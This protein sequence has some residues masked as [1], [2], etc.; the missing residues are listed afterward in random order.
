MKSR[1]QGY[2]TAAHKPILSI[3]LGAI[4]VA[5][6]GVAIAQKRG[7]LEHAVDS[8]RRMAIGDVL[9]LYSGLANRTVLHP[10]L[11]GQISIPSN[12]HATNQ[13]ETAHLL[14]QALEKRALTVIRAGE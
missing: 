3:L 13:L 11:A 6:S 8:S 12:R 1:H 7:A 4:F 14:E 9:Q 5:A 2:F 10:D